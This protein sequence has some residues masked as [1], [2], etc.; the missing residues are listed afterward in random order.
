MGAIKILV[1]VSRASGAL[2][3][4]RPQP[5]CH[6]PKFFVDKYVNKVLYLVARSGSAPEMGTISDFDSKATKV[7]EIFERRKNNMA[8]KKKA[9]KKKK[10]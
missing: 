1:T 8:T 10:H 5:S 6:K 4:P 2:L 3:W 9:A 7:R